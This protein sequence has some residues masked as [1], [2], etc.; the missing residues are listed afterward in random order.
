MKSIFVGNLSLK[1]SE[2]GLRS[3]FELYGTV[4]RVALITDPHKG[5]GFAFVEMSNDAEMEAAMT[6]LNGMS[7]GGKTLKVCEA[8]PR[9]DRAF[10]NRS[11]V[12]DK[13]VSGDARF[14]PL[15]VRSP[16]W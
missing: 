3:L 4:Q 6:A 10:S 13:D 15:R 12:Q 9:N 16:K 11:S 2:D 8:R 5:R 1:T 14:G 7:V